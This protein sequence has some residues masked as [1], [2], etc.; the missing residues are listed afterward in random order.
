VQVDIS[1]VGQPWIRV[2]RGGSATAPEHDY[3]QPTRCAL[4]IELLERGSV[5]PWTICGLGPSD[6]QGTSGVDPRTEK[7]LLADFRELYGTL[8]FANLQS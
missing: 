8:P 6:P 7:A 5:D 2:V 1:V 4:L 3:E